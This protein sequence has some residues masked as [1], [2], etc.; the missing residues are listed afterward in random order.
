MYMSDLFLITKSP[1]QRQLSGSCP[2]LLCSEIYI[3][4][5]EFFQSNKFKCVAKFKLK[6]CTPIRFG[7]FVAILFV[8]VKWKCNI[9]ICVLSVWSEKKLRWPTTTFQTTMMC[10]CWALIRSKNKVTSHCI[11]AFTGNQL[12]KSGCWCDCTARLKFEVPCS[13]F[14]YIIGA[15]GRMADNTYGFR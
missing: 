7:G 9:V 11:L 8:D 14:F 3:L 12:K 2:P 5:N 13:F 4:V 1:S 10:C 15:F 6:I